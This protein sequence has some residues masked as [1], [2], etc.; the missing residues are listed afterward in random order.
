MRL[1]IIYGPPASGKYSVAKRLSALSKYPL[2]HNH[3]ISDLE[4]TLTKND[5]SNKSQISLYTTA[6]KEKL[7]RFS[8]LY[9]QGDIKV[10]LVSLNKVNV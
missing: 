9:L 7:E 3:L 10:S 4:E 5:S 6:E 8:K 1:I 2:L